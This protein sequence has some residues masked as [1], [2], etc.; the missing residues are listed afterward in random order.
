MGHNT[1][2]VDGF[3]LV[4][5]A[6]ALG[7]AVFYDEGSTIRMP[8]YAEEILIHLGEQSLA[9]DE[10]EEG[11]AINDQSRTKEKE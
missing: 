6:T 3:D 8:S 11:Q 4:D 2:L 9:V 5:E 1:G 7:L 10:L